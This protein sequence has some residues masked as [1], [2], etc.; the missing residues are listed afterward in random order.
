MFFDFVKWLPFIL[1]VFVFLFTYY[2]AVVEYF[3]RDYYF[4]PWP[5][6]AITILSI[7]FVLMVWALFATVA[8]RNSNVPINFEVPDDVLM[9]LRLAKTEQ[10]ANDHLS[11]LC[12]KR[13]IRLWTRTPTGVIR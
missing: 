1:M 12:A 6:I 9:F 3:I 7:T 11:E 4:S 10:E 8:T 13:K 2:A 5:D